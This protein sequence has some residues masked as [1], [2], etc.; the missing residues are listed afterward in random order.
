[1]PFIELDD[2]AQPAPASDLAEDPLTARAEA[3]S[4]RADALR[5]RSVIPP[6]VRARAGG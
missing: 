5:S 3:L 2:M 1:M 4:R 6:D